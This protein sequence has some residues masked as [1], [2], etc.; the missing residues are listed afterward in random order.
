MKEFFSSQAKA[1]KR[2]LFSRSLRILPL[3][4][5]VGI[6]EG[7]AFLI[8]SFPDVLPLTDQHLLAFLSELLKM[9]SIAD[10]IIQGDTSSVS[11]GVAVNRN[12]CVCKTSLAGTELGKIALEQP[13]PSTPVHS[14]KVFLRKEMSVR[15]RLESSSS[16]DIIVPPELPMGIQLRATS[17]ALFRA[18]VN[19]HPATFFNAEGNSPAG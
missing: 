10:D 14:S 11:I 9:L 13:S 3:P 1:V 5:Q 12:G 4:D 16:R 7:L 17:L 19:K 2:T 6:V 18:V 15:D 8:S